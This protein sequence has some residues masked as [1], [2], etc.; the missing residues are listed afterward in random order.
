MIARIAVGET[1][2]CELRGGMRLK[3][4]ATTRLGQGPPT[5]PPPSP[6]KS[7]L[8]YIYTS[9]LDCSMFYLYLLDRYSS[10]RNYR[11]QKIPR[12]FALSSSK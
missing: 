6:K 8:V 12:Q 5:P 3:G 1:N 7:H 4:L 2:V 9:N 11:Y 10:Y